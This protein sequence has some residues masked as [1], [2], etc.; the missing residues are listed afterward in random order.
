LFEQKIEEYNLANGT[1]YDANAL[2]QTYFDGLYEGAIPERDSDVFH[3]KRLALLRVVEAL[4]TDLNAT[5]ESLV[6]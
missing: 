6:N 3:Q 2:L 1:A 5:V 4:R